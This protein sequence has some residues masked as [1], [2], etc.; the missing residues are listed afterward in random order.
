MEIL[1]PKVLGGKKGGP[2]SKIQSITGNSSTAVR[3]Y[4]SMCRAQIIAKSE[5]REIG[6][7]S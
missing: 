1:Y 5:H 2:V 6:V 3:L 7:C 4:S